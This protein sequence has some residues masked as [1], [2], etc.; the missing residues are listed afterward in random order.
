MSHSH[1]P[2]ASSPIHATQ[3]QSKVFAET[4]ARAQREYPVQFSQ[5]TI[6][7]RTRH[8]LCILRKL[9]GLLA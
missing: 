5:V 6:P 2:K 9:N 7:G 4:I 8:G 1:N 3:A